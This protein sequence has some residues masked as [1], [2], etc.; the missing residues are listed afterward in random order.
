MKSIIKKCLLLFLLL[1]S[2]TTTKAQNSPSSDKNYILIRTPQIAVSDISGLSSWQCTQTIDY[3]DEWGRK[4]Q[5]VQKGITSLGEDLATY[6]EYDAAGNPDKSWLPAKV[7]GNMGK[8]VPLASLKSNS[9]TTYGGD[10]YAYSLNVYENSP[11]KRIVEKYAPGTLWVGDPTGCSYTYTVLPSASV[12][13]YT[14]TGGS[15]DTIVNVKLSGM[16]AAG[17]LLVE[18]E[19]DEDYNIMKVYTDKEGRRVMEEKSGHCTYYV[20]DDRSRLRAVLPPQLSESLTTSGSTWS[21]ASSNLL[22]QYAYLYTYDGQNRCSHKRLPGTSWTFLYYDKSGQLILSQDGN[23]RKNGECTFTIPD[24]NGRT[25]LSGICKNTCP[26]SS[27][28]LQGSIVRAVRNNQTDTNKGYTIS[29]IT[30]ASPVV[31]FVS[32][33]DDYNFM[34]KNNVPASTSSLLSYESVLGYG[35]RYT[36][37]PTGFQTGEMV[38]LTDGSYLYR[39]MYYDERGRLIQSHSTNHLG[40]G[41]RTWYACDFT[42]EIIKSRHIHTAAGKT[43]RTEVCDYSYDHGGR[44]TA[45]YHQLG[46]NARIQLLSC[47]YDELGRMSGRKVHGLSSSSL[48][49][50]YNIRDWLLKI[51][52]GLFKETL[53]YTGNEPYRNLFSNYSN[54]GNICGM[55]WQSGGESVL[56]GYEFFY[57]SLDRLTIAQYSEGTNTKL[58]Q[59]VDRYTEQVTDYDKNGNILGL[60]RYGQ[61]GAAAYGL[62]DNLTFALNGNQLKSV[63]DAVAASAYNGGFEFKDGVKQANEYVYDANG[64]LTKDLNKGITGISYNCLNLPS[65]VTFSDGSTITYTYAA[66]GTKLKTVHKIGSTTTTTDYCG[67]VVY[68]NGVQ[69]LLLTDEGYVTLSDGKYHYYLKDHQGNNRVVI[70]QSGAVEETNHY[71]PFGGVFASTGNAQPYKYNGKEYDSKKGLNWYDYGARHYNA[72]L[73][74]FTTV[75]PLA[76]MEYSASSY[77]YCLNNPIKYIDPTGC[78][79][80][81][82][83]DSLGGVVAVFNDGDLGVYKHNTDFEGTKQEL[84]E[85]YSSTNT[86]AGGDRMGETYEWDSFVK[87]DTKEAYGQIDFDSFE[88]SRMVFT[89]FRFLSA[90][91]MKPLELA[92]Y[93]LNANNGEYFD[94]KHGDPYK[95]SQFGKGKYVS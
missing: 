4:Q 74:R 44:L 51:E 48:S 57:D 82:H 30:L 16:Y 33:Y 49:Y 67:N 90:L 29:G 78:L 38:R 17:E 86:A 28:P 32:Y 65:A 77:T 8:F 19:T 37:N 54:K 76:E 91:K 11:L 71:Y 46:S 23:R 20:Y 95:G 94:I 60:K 69:K 53:Y 2:F 42:G 6:Q 93:A 88:A 7:T 9:S 45:V 26:V 5:T 63:N 34:G 14:A 62:I 81:T 58:D 50:M 52:G 83:T 70:S 22:R 15:C 21:N 18:S 73:G 59:N 25:V 13:H 43:S 68:E 39:T 87:P 47:T 79:A 35:T 61:T 64:N 1:Y 24:A 3:L 36:G 10:K 31:Q 40:G 84:A 75:D 92:I 89:R 27:N 66:D 41:E 56:H 80:S 72:A 12:C 55:T 85:N